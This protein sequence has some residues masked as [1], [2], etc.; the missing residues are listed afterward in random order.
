MKKIIFTPL[1]L[2]FVLIVTFLYY[3]NN[4]KSD[5]ITTNNSL[6]IIENDSLKDELDIQ[7]RINERYEIA[8]DNFK[9]QN[10]KGAEELEECFNN[11]E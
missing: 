4:H 3:L 7:I 11:I 8:I 5:N 1:F 9:E 10:P 2:I 6:L